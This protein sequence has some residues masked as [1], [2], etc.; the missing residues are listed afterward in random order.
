[1]TTQPMQK[2]HIN[3]L[4]RGTNPEIRKL[5][6]FAHD[7]GFVI[8]HTRSQHF[9][10]TTP[11]GVSP[12]TTVFTPRTPSDTRGLHRVVA[13]LRRIGVRVPH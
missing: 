13:K 2:N 6:R 12:S 5:L 1:M 10:V 11:P 3:K 8:G 4:L 9:S 7:Q